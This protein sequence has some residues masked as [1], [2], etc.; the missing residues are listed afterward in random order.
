[1]KKRSWL[2]MIVLFLSLV[3][4]STEKEKNTAVTET[5]IQNVATV[6]ANHIGNQNYHGAYELTSVAYQKEKTE[7][8]FVQEIQAWI[9]AQGIVNMVFNPEDS[10]LE[11]TADEAEQVAWVYLIFDGTFQKNAEKFEDHE[12]MSIDVVLENG[13]LRVSNLQLGRAD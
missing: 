9:Q 6:F 7:Q 13:Q 12:A 5:Q 10:R 8:V 4:C 11:K 1:M 2:W 3:A